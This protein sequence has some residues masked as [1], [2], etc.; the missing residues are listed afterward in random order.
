[1]INDQGVFSEH[2]I[3]LF[4]KDFAKGRDELIQELT[5]K[6]SQKIVYAPNYGMSRDERANQYITNGVDI[7]SILYEY[8][9]QNS[10][11]FKDFKTLSKP[12]NSGEPQKQI[13]FLVEC[14]DRFN[15]DIK[16]RLQVIFFIT[17]CHND[18]S[19]LEFY[20]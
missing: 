4:E 2:V 6:G 20:L 12:F 8:L 17:D 16:K 1:M 11:K 7:E 18:N 3:A 9:T 5:G 10:A 19:L 15:T 13:D 14:T